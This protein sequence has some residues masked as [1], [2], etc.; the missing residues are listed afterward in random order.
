MFCS[1][2]G[3][4]IPDGTLDC[5]ACGANT[6][7]AAKVKNWK[8]IIVKIIAL[9]LIVLFFTPLFTVSCSVGYNNYEISFSGLECAI[10]K[11]VDAEYGGSGKIEGNLFAGSLLILPVV[12]LAVFFAKSKNVFKYLLGTVLSVAGLILFYMFYLEV[13]RKISGENIGLFKVDFSGAFYGSLLLYIVVI[14]LCAVGFLEDS[15]IMK[16]ELK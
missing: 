13:Y 4:E 6:G 1:K 7:T 10:G 2:C 16:R 11:N 9:A 15:R 5:P 12:L 14:I 3:V 8:S